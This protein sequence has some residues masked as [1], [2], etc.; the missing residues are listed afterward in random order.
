MSLDAMKWAFDQETKDATAKLVLVA[1]ADHFNED[2]GYSEWS[3]YQ[4][5][6]KIGCCSEKTVQR[7]INELVAVGF[8]NKVQRGFS[9]PNVYYLPMYQVYKKKQ[10]MLHSGQFDHSIQDKAVQSIQDTVV[11]HGL[12]TV[13]Q[14]GVDMGVQQTQYNTINNTNKFGGHLK[15]ELSFKQ[16]NFIE[17]LLERVAKK[18]SDPR[19]SYTN[20]E[21]LRKKMT[22]GMLKKDGSF[23]ELL[24]FY[25]LNK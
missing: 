17:V 20:F 23:E 9:K 6:A 25:E 5:I 2:L 19:Y 14:S 3:S 24:K 11:Q 16:K 12:D 10:E 4:R 7:K 1:I 21:D 18:Q 13:V 8:I 22:E 15:K